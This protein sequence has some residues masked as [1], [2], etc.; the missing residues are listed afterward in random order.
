MREILDNVEIFVLEL[1]GS[2]PNCTVSG[3][4]VGRSYVERGELTGISIKI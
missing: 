3:G 2:V 1:A 4:G